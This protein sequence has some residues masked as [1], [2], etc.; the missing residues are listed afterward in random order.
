[1]SKVVSRS[2]LNAIVGMLN[3]FIAIPNA[4]RCMLMV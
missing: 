4:D 1:M 2:V 3:Y